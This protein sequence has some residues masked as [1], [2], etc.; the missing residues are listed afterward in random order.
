MRP[1]SMSHPAGKADLRFGLCA[2]SLEAGEIERVHAAL[3][4]SGLLDGELSSP[5]A[6]YATLLL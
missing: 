4:G 6:S 3:T 5:A 2:R 1:A